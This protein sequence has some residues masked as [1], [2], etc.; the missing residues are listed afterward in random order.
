MP[1][2]TL[3][4]NIQKAK[5][6]LWDKKGKKEK[7]GNKAWKKVDWQLTEGADF[8]EGNGQG[9]GYGYGV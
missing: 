6:K 2:I 4:C 9:Y 5:E 7:K 8:I 3:L 1:M